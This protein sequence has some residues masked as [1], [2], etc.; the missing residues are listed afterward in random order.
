[1]SNGLDPDQDR[2]SVGLDLGPNCLQ[3]N[4]ADDKLRPAG[5]E[6]NVIVGTFVN[7]L[8]CEHYNT[9]MFNGTFCIE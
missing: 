9:T 1:M 2:R 7:G 8:D 5:K 3:R 6:F 4:S